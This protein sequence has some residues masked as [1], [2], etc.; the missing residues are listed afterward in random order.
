MSIARAT[1]PTFVLTFTEQALDL[2]QAAN[3]YVTFEQGKRSITKTD[4]DLTI[5][6][7]KI[8]VYLRQDETLG[9]EVGSVKIQ[10]NWTSATGA[11]ACSEVVTY[12]L[13]EQLLRTV[14]V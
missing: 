12:N 7:K 10:A 6:E 4:E 5:A 11:R 1:T 8:E 2:T 13:T 9:F 14:V 3:V